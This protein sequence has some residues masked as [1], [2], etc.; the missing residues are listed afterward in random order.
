LAR[1]RPGCPAPL[2]SGHH[3]NVVVKAALAILVLRLVDI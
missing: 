1:S 2:G 3:D